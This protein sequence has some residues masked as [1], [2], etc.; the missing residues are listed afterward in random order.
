MSDVGVH[1]A[2]APPN[3]ES[4]KLNITFIKGQNPLKRAM[5]NTDKTLNAEA[6]RRKKESWN[7]SSTVEATASDIEEIKAFLTRLSEFPV[8][9]NL[10][11]KTTTK[12]NCT[13]KIADVVDDMT[14][15]LTSFGSKPKRERRIWIASQIEAQ[16]AC[17]DTARNIKKASKMNVNIGSCHYAIWLSDERSVSLCVNTFRHVFG[18]TGAEQWSKLMED[19]KQHGASKLP[20]HGNI[21]NKHRSE[22]SPL[23]KSKGPVERH[24]KKLQ[25][26]YGQVT[27]TRFVREQTGLTTR[28]DNDDYVEL[29]SHFS[30]RKIYEQFCFEM[31]WKAKPSAKGGYGRVTDYKPR[32]VDDTL[33]PEGS[34]SLPVPSWKGFNDIWD[35]KFP[36]LKIRSPSEDICGECYLYSHS[37]RFGRR[38]GG[39]AADSNEEEDTESGV[40]S[41]TA[42]SSY[43]ENEALIAKASA[44]VKQAKAM[45]ELTNQRMDLAKSDRESGVP[46]EESQQTFVGDYAQNLDL[47]HVGAEQPGETYYYSPKN[48]YIFGCVDGATEPRQL[49]A[50]TYEEETGKKGSNNVSSLVIEY[51]HVGG[52]VKYNV[53]RSLWKGKCLSMIFD[54]CSGQNKN[55]NVLRLAAYLVE[56]GYFLE[57]EVLFY[58]RGHTKNACNRTF[59]LLK[60]YSHKQQVW[61]FP[62]LCT[63]IGKQED[64]TVVPVVAN[65]F[66]NYGEMLDEFYWQFE[67]GTVLVNHIFHVTSMDPGVMVTQE[68]P[69]KPEKTQRIIKER[70]NE[71]A[72]ARKLRLNGFVLKELSPPGLREIKVVELATKWRPLVPP[73]FQDEICPIPDKALIDRVK[74]D[75]NNKKK[76]REQEKR[77]AAANAMTESAPV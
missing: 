43:I 24:L 36:N 70:R 1:V 34:E 41:P 10:K 40:D 2:G 75:R 68:D 3:E 31:G 42:V 25:D 71:D 46:F 32:E 37:F 72:A 5:A 26:D 30:K 27:A 73:Q 64:I 14:E 4:I 51:L 57:V 67:T 62:Q 56:C 29:P 6:K 69:D 52:L 76:K 19:V 7:A 60:K 47:P 16:M 21:G 33:W 9:Y 66:K 38:G 39:S 13:T 58:V 59:N 50:F 65:K 11:N 12:C 63:V 44:H 61:T 49:T 74:K 48:V 8:C 17:I 45:R 28:D 20:G 35:D 22:N 55:N 54:N 77:D 15:L 23:G 18:I 53:D